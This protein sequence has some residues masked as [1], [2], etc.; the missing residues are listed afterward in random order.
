MNRLITE[1]DKKIAKHALLVFLAFI[2]ISGLS[3]YGAFWYSGLRAP[4]GMVADQVPF[5]DT[6]YSI[7]TSS[8]LTFDETSGNFTVGGEIQGT[9]YLSDIKADGTAGESLLEGNICFQYTDG[10][11]YRSDA[12]VSANCTTRMAMAMSDA[13]TDDSI[14]F[15]EF[16]YITNTDWT[17]TMGATLF[18]STT[19]GN[20][21]ETA[22]S[23]SG[24]IVRIIGYG[25][26]NANK[27]KVDID[28]SWVE[29][30]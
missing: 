6:T 10:K 23:G 30:E 16:G 4:V 24:D 9:I 3:G 27:V 26:D 25:T 22:P 2:V 21:T 11:W 5:A 12:D 14:D 17:V 15:I 7:G 19:T 1:L 13:S 20:F 8:N 28:N 29:L 18:A